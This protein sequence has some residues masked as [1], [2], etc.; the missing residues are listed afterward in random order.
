MH[1]MQPSVHP[2]P[3]QLQQVGQQPPNLYQAAPLPQPQQP[4]VSQASPQE[5]APNDL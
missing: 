1:A 4:A 5:S 3:Q 2:M